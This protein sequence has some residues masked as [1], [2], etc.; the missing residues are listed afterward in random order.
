[1]LRRGA[2][3]RRGILLI[4]AAMAAG[5]LGVV[6]VAAVHLVGRLTEERR[7]LDRRQFA[8]VAVGNVMERVAVRSYDALTAEAL[9]DVSI[10]ATTARFLVDAR[11]EVKV[12]EV[13]E[14]AGGMIGKWITVELR[15]RGAGGMDEHP[16]RLTTWRAR[17]ERSGS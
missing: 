2:R 13:E 6:L 11:L 8:V 1:M 14:T 17:L 3:S 4:D 5:V 9:G 10:D 12:H 15:W 7:S 16:V